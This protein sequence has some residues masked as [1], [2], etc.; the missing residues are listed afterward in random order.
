MRVGVLRE[1][2]DREYRVALTPDG[3]RGLVQAGHDVL[4]ESGAGEGSGFPDDLYLEAGASTAKSPE[5][6]I[7][8]SELVTKVKEPT[9]EEVG[10][11]RPGQ[12]LYCFLH[13]APQPDLTRLLLERQVVAIGFETVQTDDG[14]LPILV[15]MSEVAGRLSV[16]VGA[17]Y[18]QRDQGGSGVLLG[19][20]PGVPRG[21]VCILGAGVVGTA[22]VRVAV[23]L[24]AEV[25]VLDIDHRRLA[26]LYDLYRGEIGTLH[27]NPAS[28]ERAVREADLLVGAV[29]RPGAR[30]SVLVDRALVG[31]MRRGSVI[32][33]TAV[34]QGGCVET[35]HAT[36]HSDPVYVT[37]GVIHY[38]VANMPGAVPRT[39]TL[40]L[41]H[42]S[43]PYLLE[44]CTRGLPGALLANRALAR[45]VNCYRGSVTHPGLA[46][47]QS[48]PL[49]STPWER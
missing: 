9:T 26:W 6:V 2:K 43:L 31:R 37:N 17:H 22:A 13:L 18:L 33:D 21:R 46:E 8:G 29:L 19:G 42:A 25:E 35:I 30:A 3:V 48:L 12:G 14:T 20:V 23:G 11:M 47:A 4:I 49:E 34:D 5:E 15:P 41:A 28:V 45:G 24:G 10:I 36:T 32:V 1:R 27:S 16:Q 44:V 40:A 38:G 39:S 7:E